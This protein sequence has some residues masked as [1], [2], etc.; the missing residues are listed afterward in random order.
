MVYSLKQKQKAVN[1]LDRVIG[2]SDLTVTGVALRGNEK[3]TI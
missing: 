1:E 2:D 3:N